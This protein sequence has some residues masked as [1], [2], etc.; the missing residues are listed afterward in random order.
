M[1]RK[2]G[3]A[4]AYS[5]GNLSSN[6]RRRIVAARTH[7]PLRQTSCGMKNKNRHEQSSIF[8]PSS[9]VTLRYYAINTQFLSKRFDMMKRSKDDTRDARIRVNK[10]PISQ[11]SRADQVDPFVTRTSLVSHGC[12]WNDL[13]S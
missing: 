4:T 10:I 8:D 11:V 3:A 5:G 9:F 1:E 6:R 13:T 7:I 12:L 2:V